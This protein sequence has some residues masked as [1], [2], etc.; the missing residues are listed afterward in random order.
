MPPEVCSSN[1]SESC[2]VYPSIDSYAF[3]VSFFEIMTGKSPLH[4]IQHNQ[5]QTYVEESHVNWI[6]GYEFMLRCLD[7]DPN[8]R[9]LL[10]EIVDYL[11]DLKEELTQYCEQSK[12]MLFKEYYHLKFKGLYFPINDFKDFYCL[13]H[14][15]RLCYMGCIGE[16]KN[17]IDE[18]EKID[19][20]VVN[21]QDPMGGT[22]IFYA[23]VQKD[24]DLVELLL[25]KKVDLTLCCDSISPLYIA[26]LNECSEIVTKILDYFS[27]DDDDRNLL[28]KVINM[29]DDLGNTPLFVCCYE[30]N[31]EIAEMLVNAGADLNISNHSGISPIAVCCQRGHHKIWSMLLKKGA[32]TEN[33]FV[34][35]DTIPITKNTKKIKL[36][37]DIY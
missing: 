10:C 33:V 8:E 5:R 24:V 18:N 26:C 19:V 15:H 25:Q 4:W 32:T 28:S 29:Q 23:C 9:P 31:Y 13:N 34:V 7:E 2:E 20:D 30:G 6:P 1:E 36:S 12:G 11:K 27:D 14:I 16:V 22:P 21:E 3:G 17:L 37:F 35:N